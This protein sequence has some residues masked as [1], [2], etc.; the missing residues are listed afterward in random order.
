MH[1]IVVSVLGRDCPGVVHAVA[2]LLDELGCNIEEVSQ[3]ILQAE[4]AAIIIASAPDDTQ[5]SRVQS[6]LNQG[7]ADR[8]MDLTVTARP[9]DLVKAWTPEKS[10]LFVV[11][12]HGPDRKGLIVGVT[13]VFA[14]HQVN[15]ENLKALFP[16]DDPGQALILFEVAL[17]VALDRVMFR[18]ELQ[19]EADRLGVIISFQHRDIF[20]AMHRVLPV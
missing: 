4:F 20:E 15:I 18:R 19:T 5:L 1:K 14:K 17:P 8:R 13:S 7:L 2:S 3:T 11:T 16:E 6:I 9:F 12:V 10:E